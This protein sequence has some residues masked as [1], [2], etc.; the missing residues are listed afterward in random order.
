MVR[1]D[2]LFDYIVSLEN[3]YMAFREAWRGKRYAYKA[4]AA[5]ARIETIITDIIREMRNGT[6][7]PG[8]YYSFECRT[9]VK[10]R[11]INAPS[12][13]DGIAH[14]AIDA[15]VRPLF[16]RKYI[17]DLYSNRQGKGQHKA[18][19]RVQQ[20]IRR[21]GSRGRKVYVLQCDI[22]HYYDSIDHALLKETVRATIKDSRVL[23]LIDAIIDSYNGDTGKGV[24]IG[25]LP[26][27]T[28]ANCYLSRFDHW[29]KDDRR[30]RF[31]LRFMDDFIVVSDDKEEL[32]ST[33]KDICWYMETQAKL[34]LNPKTQI[35]PASR[36]TDFCGYRIF[37]DKI[38]PR[39]RNIKAAKIRFKNISYL[40]RHGYIRVEDVR[41]LVMSFLGYCKHCKAE[42]SVR[43]ALAYL[44]LTRAHGRGVR[45]KGR[46]Y[47]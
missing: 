13:R 34:K 31:Y 30:M 10:R 29:M 39:K 26:S 19:Q 32:R 12:F 42:R 24:P 14:H 22:H 40:Y 16:E 3:F 38:L 20:F 46:P 11:R 37:S 27:Q 15:V 6:W 43:S 17:Y 2:D 35:F 1:Y 21:A 5:A 36:G 28:F 33:L 44:T 9:E 23:H 47:E 8:Q 25:A 7:K 18:V 45:E 41:P 4:M